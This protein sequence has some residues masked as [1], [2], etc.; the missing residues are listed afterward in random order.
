VPCQGKFDKIDKK[1]YSRK[2]SRNGAHL[3]KRCIDMPYH[4]VVGGEYMHGMH[5]AHGGIPFMRV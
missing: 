2:Q 4:W 3:K 1:A 5:I